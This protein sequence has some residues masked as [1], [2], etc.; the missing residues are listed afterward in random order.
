[1]ADPISWDYFRSGTLRWL[2]E[3]AIALDPSDPMRAPIPEGPGSVAFQLEMNPRLT[4]WKGLTIFSPQGITLGVSETRDEV[5]QGAHL[6][7]ARDRLRNA[8]IELMKAKTFGIHTG[9]YRLNVNDMPA[10]WWGYLV[11]FNWWAANGEW[12]G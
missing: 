3:D 6:V 7:F 2:T 11:R 12:E 9:M 1:M 8:T 5:K 4:W 10:E